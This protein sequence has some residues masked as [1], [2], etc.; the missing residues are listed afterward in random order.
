MLIVLSVGVSFGH[1][2]FKSTS[3]LLT[4][5]KQIRAL[6][7]VRVHAELNEIMRLTLVFNR[8]GQ[9]DWSDDV[10]ADA[11][12]LLDLLYVRAEHIDRRLAEPFNYEHNRQSHV[13]FL[14]F[15]QE[16]AA[17]VAALRRL[18][19]S[20]DGFFDQ[21]DVPSKDEIQVMASEI[22]TSRALVFSFLDH[23]SRIDSE[24]RSV[25]E[26]RTE[27]LMRFVLVFLMTGSFGVAIGI[28]LLRA[29]VQ[30]RNS[31][32]KAES[33]AWRLAYYDQVTGLAN[34]AR[35]TDVVEDAVSRSAKCTVVL[36]DLDHFKDINDRH[37]HLVGDAVLQMVASRIRETSATLTGVAA[38][39]GGD[40]FAVF[41]ETD[42]IP[43]LREFC[44]RLLST[45]REPMQ[46]DDLTLTAGYS[47]GMVTSSQLS[48]SRETRLVDMMRAADFA[49]YASKDAG[50][51]CYTLY[52]ADLEAQFNIRREMV[53]AMP[54]AVVNEEFEIFLQPKVDL[55]T[56]KATSFEALVRWRRGD[57]VKSPAE[58]I[59]VAEETGM[60][61]DIDR[62]MLDKSL[63][64]M[65]A[66][67]TKYQTNFSVSVNLS[68]LHF[69]GD[70][71][72][73]FVEE[74]LSK[75]NYP[76]ELLTLEITE[77]VQLKNWGSVGK[78]L[79]G[80]RALGCK[81]SIDDFGAGYS[82]L[83][84][85]RMIDADELKIDRALVREIETSDEA[86]FILDTVVELAE[87][88]GLSVVVE[89]IEKES[90]L[91]R[92]RQMGCRFGQGYLFSPPVPAEEALQAALNDLSS[93][94]KA[95]S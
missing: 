48:I 65:G 40:E 23:L 33:R 81:I 54:D 76:P 64:I 12:F 16:G 39:L 93:A 3:E 66:W 2:T 35:F 95:V 24:L 85:L 86:Q 79:A 18:I 25:Q 73:G 82:S 30:A 5:S 51:D 56:S 78:S 59:S 22:E 1:W 72:L 52:D 88:F 9:G 43:T 91:E 13:Y 62:Y 55:V 41:V 27:S 47:I 19:A 31:R 80:L 68:A 92:L 90:Q 15:D 60:V 49:L 11:R 63:E 77:T 61:V 8:V 32:E 20:S 45:C 6:S 87:Q 74:T 29:E 50:R 10:K 57:D 70:G 21:R 46:L 4:T 69:R 42:D 58:F 38:R 84:Y 7:A 17:A 14:D 26:D 94:E 36:L 71:D 37:G 34:R 28:H 75:Y 89:G 44:E 67:N 53:N 83:A